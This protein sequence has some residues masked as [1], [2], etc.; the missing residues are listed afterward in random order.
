M[1]CQRTTVDA[2]V[3]KCVFNHQIVIFGFRNLE[4]MAPNYHPS[5][6]T[7][8]TSSASCYLNTSHTH[9]TLPLLSPLRPKR[10]Y[11]L[12]KGVMCCPPTSVDPP[13]A[14]NPPNGASKN[15][16]GSGQP[17]PPPPAP[18]SSVARTAGSL[19]CSEPECPAQWVVDEV[20]VAYVGVKRGTTTRMG[21]K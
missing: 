13:P 15:R 20:M 7:P 3:R 17:L 10:M 2:I 14:K 1:E 9:S 8:L 4:S 19:A 6:R 21:S 12:G 5:I 16:G 11:Q 18:P